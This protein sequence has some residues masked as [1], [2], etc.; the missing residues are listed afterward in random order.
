[1][2]YLD[3]D[4]LISFRLYNFFELLHVMIPMIKQKIDQNSF[5]CYRYYKNR[6]NVVDLIIGC[7]ES[8]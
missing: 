6:L 2:V 5:N 4:S 7:I 8:T 3:V 1:M